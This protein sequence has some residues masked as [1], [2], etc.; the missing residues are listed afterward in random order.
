MLDFINNHILQIGINENQ[1]DL[2][3]RRIILTNT[4]NITIQVFCFVLLCFTVYYNLMQEFIVGVAALC[5]TTLVYWLN[6]KEKYLAAS[7]ALINITCASIFSASIIAYNFSMLAEPENWLFAFVTV[8]VFL[9]DGFLLIAQFVFIFLEILIAKL[10]KYWTIENDYGRDF[11]LLI[12]NT[13]VHCLGLYIFL[14]FIKKDH[15]KTQH[16]LEESNR[17]KNKLLSIL[18]H[19]IR[20][21]LSNLQTL[22]SLN[23]KGMLEEKDF[24]RHKETVNSKIGFLTSEIDDVVEWSVVQ[25]ENLDPKIANFNAR[26]CIQKVTA[27]FSHF[28][29]EKSIVIQLKGDVEEIFMDENHF[30]L[31]I[32]NLLHNAIK[33]T[34]EN[35]QIKISTKKFQ[36]EARIEICDSGIGMTPEVVKTL[37]S[38]GKTASL[39]GT[40]GEK[41][42]GLGLTMCMDL[43]E[44]NQIKLDIESKPN[45]GSTF[46][47]WIPKE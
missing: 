13:A 47:L 10:F 40:K 16:K 35:G 20:S 29:S 14:I 1:N 31:I 45:V 41:G 27:M 36:K 4:L 17:T 24:Q 26:D 33:F 15:F 18:A 25:S 6:Y 30:K 3:K 23:E 39:N 12:V 11:V 42:T 8:A 7:L 19:D 44:R 46:R 37:M 43:I 34:S 5:G 28:C 21:P 32:R 22:L 38:Q 9:L 2:L